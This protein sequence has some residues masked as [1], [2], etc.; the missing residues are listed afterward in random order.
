MTSMARRQ[1]V[2][3]MGCSLIVPPA[4]AQSGQRRLAWF[5][6]GKT[7]ASAAYLEAMRSGLRERG[8]E[9]GRKIVV[10]QSRV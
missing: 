3:A 5:G 10:T 4:R 1:L 6:A 7:G 2:V 8:W 9:Q